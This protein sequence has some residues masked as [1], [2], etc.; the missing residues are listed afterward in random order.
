MLFIV[1]AAYIGFGINR[2][3]DLAMNAR[4][5]VASEALQLRGRGLDSRAVAVH[6]WIG[7][8]YIFEAVR[9]DDAYVFFMSDPQTPDRR[10]IIFSEKGLPSAFSSGDVKTTMLA[11]WY[12]FYDTEWTGR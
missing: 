8:F 1:C 7:G 10:G 2:Y 9:L 3:F 6:D 12:I 5:W 4:L 11:H